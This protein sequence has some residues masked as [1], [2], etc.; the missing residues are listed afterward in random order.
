MFPTV[1]DSNQNNAAQNNVS[2]NNSPQTGPNETSAQPGVTV[3]GSVQRAEGAGPA[4][5]AT[6]AS[7]S[8]NTNA[9]TAA[10][11]PGLSQ[12]ATRVSEALPAQARP[13]S[14][15]SLPA[16]QVAVNIQRAVAAGQ[17]RIRITL[18]PA[19]LGQIDIKLSLS[20]DGAVKAIVSIERPETFELLQ[21]DARGLEKALQDAGLKTDSNSLSF[22]L[23]GEEERNT[24]ANREDRETGSQDDGTETSD[25]PELAPEIIAAANAN[26]AGHTLDLHV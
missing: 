15:A 17:D 10:G 14:A 13:A 23:K 24:A 9:P 6:N 21:R 3:P 26:G 11:I 5:T 20:S 18:H 8:A 2:Q 4:N 1:L 25:S 7:A 12:A 16:N 22:N 19:E